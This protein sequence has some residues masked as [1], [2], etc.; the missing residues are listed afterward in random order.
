VLNTKAFFRVDFGVRL[1]IPGPGNLFDS[2][3]ACYMWLRFLQ[4]ATEVNLPKVVA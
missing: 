2:M 3:D 4:L 1:A